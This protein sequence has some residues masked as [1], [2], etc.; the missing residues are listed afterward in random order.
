VEPLDS[1]S[2][3]TEGGYFTSTKKL[4]NLSISGDA[5]SFIVPLN[6]DEFSVS[7]KENGEI[8]NKVYKVVR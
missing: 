5:V 3:P 4:L 8:V 6:I 2:I 1:I 7:V